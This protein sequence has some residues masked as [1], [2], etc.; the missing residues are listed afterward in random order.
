MY[1]VSALYSG[2]RLCQMRLVEPS[3]KS[4]NSGD[5][6]L[7][8]TSNQAYAWVGDYCN[9]IEKA[10]VNSVLNEIGSF[11]I[12]FFKSKKILL[13]YLYCSHEVDTK[14]TDM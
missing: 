6:Y 7:L 13:F 2:R 8:I 9:V 11:S 3:F 4:I 5:A 10:K 1:V 14:F 12:L